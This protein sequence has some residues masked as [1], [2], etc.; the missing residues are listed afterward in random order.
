MSDSDSIDN[1]VGG[2]KSNGHKMECKCPI[3][4]NMM[5]KSL[6]SK[7]KSKSKSGGQS[8]PESDSVSFGGKKSNGH[9]MQCKCP[10]CKNMMKKKG[11]QPDPKDTI[12][13]DVKTK[14]DIV[15]SNDKDSTSDSMSDSMSDSSDSMSDSPRSPD[16]DTLIGQEDKASAIGNI[17]SE[18]GGKRRTKKARKS[19]KSKKSRKSRKEMLGWQKW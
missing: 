6:K 12:I 2:K 18:K 5:Y 17:P 9:K 14:N 19:K 8:E 13:D 15:K 11:G 10:I 4:K 3:C 1:P 7:T 16:S